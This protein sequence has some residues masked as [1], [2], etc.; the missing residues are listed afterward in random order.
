MQSTKIRQGGLSAEFKA[1]ALTRSPSS[2]TEPQLCLSQ[3][4]RPGSYSVNQLFFFF[5]QDGVDNNPLVRAVA[6]IEMRQYTWKHL[7]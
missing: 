6:E 2:D 7:V 4:L 5:L 3:T 1:P